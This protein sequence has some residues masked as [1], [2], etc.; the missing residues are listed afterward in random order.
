MSWHEIHKDCNWN[1][2]QLTRHQSTSPGISEVPIFLTEHREILVFGRRVGNITNI[3]ENSIVVFPGPF[4][5]MLRDNGSGVDVVSIVEVVIV[6]PV[7]R[8]RAGSRSNVSHPCEPKI[9]YNQRPE[10]SYHPLP[11]SW[12]TSARAGQLGKLLLQV[13]APSWPLTNSYLQP[14]LTKPLRRQAHQKEARRQ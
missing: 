2:L 12:F 11:K 9:R 8:N 13:P 1:L 10:S 3:E 7:P 14:Q 4:G 6:V 5:A